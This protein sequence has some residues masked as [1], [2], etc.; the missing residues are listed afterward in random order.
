[1]R[2][3]ARGQGY[4]LFLTD[5]AAVLTL[6]KRG[7][8]DSKPG[9]ISPF[10]KSTATEPVKTDVVRMELAGASHGLRVS[11][12][13]QLPGRPTTSSATIR[14]SGTAIFPPTAK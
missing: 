3:L 10:G 12:A 14:P 5:S 8:P 7:A 13:E 9:Q 1:M 4:S 6:T 11:G 2:F